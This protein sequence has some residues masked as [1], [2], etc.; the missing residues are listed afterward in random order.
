VTA[1]PNKLTIRVKDNGIGIPEEDIKNLFEP[2]YRASN[3]NDVEGTGLGLSII[4]KAL[5]LL[6]GYID[7]KSTLGKGTEITIVIP[8]AHA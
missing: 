3:A 6:R 1:A 4:R 2:F 5:D 7:I 8:L